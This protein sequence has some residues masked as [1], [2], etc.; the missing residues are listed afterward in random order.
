MPNVREILVA[1]AE[2]PDVCSLLLT[3]NTRR[4]RRRSSPI[5]VW[6]SVSGTGLL[7][8]ARR[9]H[10]DRPGG[11]SWADQQGCR[12]RP[13]AVFV[14]GD[15]PHD[16]RCAP[17]W[18]RERSGSQ[19]VAMRRG[20]AA[21]APGECSK[22]FRRRRSSSRSSTNESWPPMTE[23][24]PGGGA[25]SDDAPKLRPYGPRRRAGA[26]VRARV[27]FLSPYD[28]PEF[29]DG[30]GARSRTIGSR[31]AGGRGRAR[32]RR[33][34]AVDLALKSVH[35]TG[36][37]LEYPD[38]SFQ[39]L[40][41]SRRRAAQNAVARALTT[42]VPRVPESAGGSADVTRFIGRNGRRW[43]AFDRV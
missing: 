16:I 41:P 34:H 29:L 15:T 26:T 37:A 21:E 32:D 28:Q 2:L 22:S 3:G 23:R 19:P 18:A 38:G 31:H 11:A 4:A 12:V 14:V 8:R 13:G 36:F 27:H 43:P 20:V 9:P 5:T 6:R 10:R 39:N 35:L 30:A 17:R 1:L 24:H 25:L 42:L 33:G 7:R 40:E